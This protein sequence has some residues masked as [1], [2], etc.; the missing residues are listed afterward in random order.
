MNMI[1]GGQFSSRI[2][3][4]LREQHG[5]TYDAYSQIAFRRSAGPFLAFGAVR[6]DTTADSIRQ[7]FKEINGVRDAPVPEAELAGAKEAFARSLPGAFDTN[8][9]SVASTAT[10]FLYGLP[11]DYFGKLPASIAMVSSPD[12][13]RVARQYLQPETMTVIAVGDR[14][15]IAPTVDALGIR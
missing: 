1:L 11:L 14:A 9:D 4:N 15:K 2:N 6:T 12:V 5:Y 8:G 13:Q 10:I 7:I 3:M